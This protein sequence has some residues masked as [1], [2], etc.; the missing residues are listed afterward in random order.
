M[1]PDLFPFI[2]SGQMV[3]MIG[4]LAGAAEYES[5]IGQ[6][7]RASA[8]MRPQSVTH[9]III[10]FILLANITFFLSRRKAAR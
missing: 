4:G 10:T 8:G 9:I 1:A 7:D 5:L 6:A 3:G 2:Q